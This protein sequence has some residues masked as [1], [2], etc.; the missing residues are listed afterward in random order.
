[1]ST[2]NNVR[3]ILFEGFDETSKAN[4]VSVDFNH[5]LFTD[6]SSSINR[7]F[8]N[9]KNLTTVTNI[10]NSLSNLDGMFMNCV[11][12]TNIP[13]S[14]PTSTT[15]L[16]YTFKDASGLTEIPAI[17]NSVTDISYGFA[18][19][20]SLT[21]IQS[22][23]IP[24]SVTNFASAFLN[25]NSLN[26]ALTVNGTNGLNF[27]STFSGCENLTT[28]NIII[29][30]RAS[31]ITNIFANCY[32]LTNLNFTYSSIAT[33]SGLSSFSNAFRDC[34]NVS[35]FPPLPNN[36][37]NISYAFYNCQNLTE[38][39]CTSDIVD[40]TG[41]F[42]GCINLQTVNI[43]NGVTTV[44]DAFNNCI[45]LSSITLPASITNSM[46][47]TFYNCS[48]LTTITGNI[49]AD[50]NTLVQTFYNCKNI[51]GTIHIESNHITNAYQIFNGTSANKSVYIPMKYENG[52]NTITYNSFKN[53]GYSRTARY[54]GVILKPLNTAYYTLTVE[55][56]PAD[57]TLVLQCEGYTQV[58]RTITVPD[59]SEVNYTV[60]KEGYD[61]RS[62][63]FIV[64]ETKTEYVDLD[65]TVATY[66]IIPDPADAN[67]TLTASGYSQ[68]G[69][70][71]TVPVNTEV[72]WT[73]SKNGY[74]SRSGTKTVTQ[75]ETE[76]VELS[77]NLLTY[78]IEPTPSDA[79][80]TLTAY[81]YTQVGNSI[82]VEGGTTVEWTV[83]KTKYISQS[84]SEIVTTDTTQY[85]ELIELVTVTISPTPVSATVTL[86]ASGYTQVG[87]TITVP[88]GTT[89]NYTVESAGY[90]SKSGTRIVST[91]VVIPVELNPIVILTV[92]TVPSGATITLDAEHYY[93]KGTDWISV[94]AGE[95]VD[96]NVVH[97][98]Y[99]EQS[100]TE[101]VNQTKTKTI[102]L[103]PNGQY[104]IDLTNYNYE[105][106][107][108]NLVLTDYIG[109]STN[110]VMPNIGA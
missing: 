22:G 81:G 83:S 88:T 77:Y 86:T 87:N 48:N 3:G 31:N 109:S 14:F 15:N 85:V 16:S 24:N 64:T 59:E 30:N 8:Y 58:G 4:V 57:A 9:A 39:N 6:N 95:S 102:T 79:T 82:D 12:L 63:V 35:T 89:V 11:N 2:Y 93:E 103:V 70:S 56:N 96:W 106:S 84:G 45:S 49:S 33:T 65:V 94:E 10:S 26:T 110:V 53:A 41:A 91:D 36:V 72:A 71:I 43:N 13:D 68:I 69:N 55:T 40:M 62:G 51:T 104:N 105:K 34:R 98:E 38:Y 108:N 78:T 76:Y 101:V 21:T 28:V 18:E 92:E 54:D 25:C 37:T 99:Y 100:G 73:V 20:T 7:S 97:P 50:V 107:N 74:G 27:A 67:V 60:S 44:Q 42:S 32:N 17:P 80:V 29:G 90:V 61:T 52:V 46:D 19:C 1:M 66:T 47:K 23:N 75:T 5:V